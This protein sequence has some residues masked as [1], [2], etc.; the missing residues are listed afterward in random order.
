M[1]TNKRAKT[2]NIKT[3][4]SLYENKQTIKNKQNIY[5][6]FNENKQTSKHKQNTN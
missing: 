6:T 4:H 1:E 5:Q 3:K 2:D